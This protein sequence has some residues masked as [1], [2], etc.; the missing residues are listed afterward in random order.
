MKIKALFVALSM[1]LILSLAVVGGWQAQDRAAAADDSPSAD[2]VQPTDHPILSDLRVRQAIAYCTNKDTLVLSVYPALTPTERQ[3]LILDTFIPESSWAYSEP[4]IVYDYDPV[5]GQA[6]LDQAGWLQPAPGE[7]RVKD[8]KE[9]YLELNTTDTDFRKTF[10][11]VFEAQMQACG[12][13]VKRNHMTSQWLFAA[14]TGVQVRDFELADFAWMSETDDPGGYSLYACEQI[15]APENGWGGQNYMG[16]CNPEASAAIEI[17][18]DTSQP[19]DVRADQFAIVIDKLAEDVPTLPLFLREGT[20]TWEHIDFNLQIYA[21]DEELSP[22]GTDVTGNLNYTDY[23]GIQHTVTAPAG[24]VS[25]ALDLRY[26][27]LVT[28][29][30]P[31][32]DND[33]FLEH[34]FRLNA[35]EDGVP[36][37]GFTFTEPITLIVHYD[38]AD[39]VHHYRENSLRLY[40]WECAS[41]TWIAAVETCP[42]AD[43]YEY[44]DMTNNLYAVHVCHLS[45]FRFSGEGANSR[46]GV[47]YAWDHA[48]GIYEV[49]HIITTTLKDSLGQVKA[50]AIELTEAG[51]EGTGTGELFA[52][53]DGFWVQQ[54]EWSDP[55]IDI[56]PGDRVEFVSDDGFWET[57]AV[58]QIEAEFNTYTASGWGMI[59]APDA[60][61]PLTGSA[62][63]WGLFWND[64]ELAPDGSFTVSFGP[65][66]LTPGMEVTVVYSEVD[67]DAV[68]NHFSFPDY[69][70]TLPVV[71]VR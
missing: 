58:G 27:P 66:D 11:A 69:Q 28:N 18:S 16:W 37:E 20:T 56:V 2:P 24:A 1:G 29:F 40:A 47:D 7:Y 49:G 48:A 26:Y 46:M 52:W 44:L 6:L 60:E 33:E 43:R 55:N 62:G 23:Q 41:E 4:S 64:I 38:L 45:E 12:I 15:P 70:L 22:L 36:V 31:L 53:S 5:E 65:A 67:G 54:D 21:Q 8:G 30:E 71:V 35:V 17:A 51:G 25:E 14:T 59:T 3:A 9:L 13:H 68:K 61:G 57:L 63:W 10:L 50:T 39:V 32:D 19:Q 34:A 42:V